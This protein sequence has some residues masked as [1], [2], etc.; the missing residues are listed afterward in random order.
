VP[1]KEK[2][3]ML[4]SE[5]RVIKETKGG[6]RMRRPWANVRIKGFWEK[7]A[8]QNLKRGELA[9]A[10]VKKKKLLRGGER[11]RGLGHRIIS[12]VAGGGVGGKKLTRRGDQGESN[13]GGVAKESLDSEQGCMLHKEWG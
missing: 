11:G 7:K 8:Q 5:R 13:E 1:K 6:R 9:E 12:S 3:N 10:A 4:V 2:K